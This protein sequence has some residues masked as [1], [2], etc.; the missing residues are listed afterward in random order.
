M[1]KIALTGGIACGKSL[2]GEIMARAGI[3]ICETDDIGHAVMEQDASVKTSLVKAFG[4]GIIGPDGGIDRSILGQLVFEDP[5][6]RAT[7]NA[8]THPAILRRLE[9]WV[10]AQA[11]TADRVAAIIPLLY[12]IGAEKA[13]DVVICVAAQETDQLRRLMERGHSPED[14]HAR[15]GAQM[16]LSAKMERAD[17]V[18]YNCD[19]KA[20]LEEQVNQV[21]RSIRGD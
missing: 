21:L 12:E 20:L 5:G 10:T 14:A 2:V 6:K 17:Y 3:P 16:S 19:G 15:I 1:I 4:I 8:L 7:L 9:E 13:W 11:A 18:I